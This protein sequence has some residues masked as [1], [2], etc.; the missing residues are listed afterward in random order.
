M[1]GKCTQPEVVPAAI[2]VV[3]RSRP[4]GSLTALLIELSNI[5]DN[6]FNNMYMYD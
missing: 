4:M 6:K 2:L 5:I 3:Y 1:H